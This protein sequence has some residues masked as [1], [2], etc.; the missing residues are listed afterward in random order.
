MMI[1]DEKKETAWWWTD[2]DFDLLKLCT[3]SLWD[4]S[5]DRYE[6]VFVLNYVLGT[7]W[8]ACDLRRM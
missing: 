8:P 6:L 5:D 4:W 3:P 7:E 1:D 2:L